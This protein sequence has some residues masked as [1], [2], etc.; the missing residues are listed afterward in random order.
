MCIGDLLNDQ[1]IFKISI[2]KVLKNT[3]YNLK[4]GKQV[5]FNKRNIWKSNKDVII[6]LSS[7]RD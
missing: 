4:G 2:P 5:K 1:V 7:Y 3:D 6:L